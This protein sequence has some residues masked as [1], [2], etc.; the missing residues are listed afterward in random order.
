[1]AA[2]PEA[3]G[4]HDRHGLFARQSDELIDSRAKFLRGHVVGV[5]AE[6][7]ASKGDVRRIRIAFLPVA[8]QRLAEPV[9]IDPWGSCCESTSL[10]KCGYRFELGKER[11]SASASI[12]C[13]RSSPTSSSSDRVE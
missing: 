5:V 1:M 11:M 12:P 3:L 8:S 2:P 7:R 10:W 13:S 6:S 9:I 4:T